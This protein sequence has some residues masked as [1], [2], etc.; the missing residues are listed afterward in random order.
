MHHLYR[1]FILPTAG[2]LLYVALSV[3]CDSLWYAA[4]STLMMRI[5]REG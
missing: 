3:L 5:E 1:K 4:L 2:G